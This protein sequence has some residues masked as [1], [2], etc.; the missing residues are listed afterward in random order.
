MTKLEIIFAVEG[1]GKTKLIVRDPK[2]NLTKSVVE[3]ATKN[4]I[5]VLANA[6]GI[7]VVA[8]EKA[9]KVSRE[10]EELE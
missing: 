9:Q 8:F 4:I 5:P 2:E 10:I 1:G 6:S 7:K 3:E